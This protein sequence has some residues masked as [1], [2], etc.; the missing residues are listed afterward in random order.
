MFQPLYS[1]YLER[2]LKKGQEAKASETT[3]GQKSQPKHLTY[4]HKG[5][6]PTKSC[7]LHE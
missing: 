5:S 3:A 4:P 7:R 6:D 1:A 2:R